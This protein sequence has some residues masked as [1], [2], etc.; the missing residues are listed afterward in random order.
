MIYS[1]LSLLHETRNQSQRNKKIGSRDRRAWP[2]PLPQAV[3]GI[4]RKK[5]DLKY[6]LFRCRRE[7]NPLKPTVAIWVQL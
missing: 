2:D 4:E 1:Q 3:D 6:D 5:Y 7:I